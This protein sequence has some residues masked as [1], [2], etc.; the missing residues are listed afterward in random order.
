M[1]YE[2]SEMDYDLDESTIFLF[3]FL[4]LKTLR[5]VSQIHLL[6]R[7]NH[8]PFHSFDNQI[9]KKLNFLFKNNLNENN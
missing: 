5:L 9:F 7:L 4:L 6:I 3:F 2:K 1:D 8:S